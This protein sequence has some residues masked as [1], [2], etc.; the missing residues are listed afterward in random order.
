MTNHTWRETVH[1]VLTLLIALGV[2]VL[3][4]LSLGD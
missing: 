3:M 2:I 4:A 1:T